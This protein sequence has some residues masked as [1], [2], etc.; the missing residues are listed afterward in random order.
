MCTRYEL[1]NRH[2]YRQQIDRQTRLEIDGQT[3]RETCKHTL[4]IDK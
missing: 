2:I 4:L 3:G 1:S